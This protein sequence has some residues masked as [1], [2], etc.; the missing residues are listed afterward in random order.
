[1]SGGVDCLGRGRGCGSLGAS[2]L[3][4]RLSRLGRMWK[5]GLYVKACQVTKLSLPHSNR[6]S[7]VYTLLQKTDV[8][9]CFDHR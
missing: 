5:L 8:R 2:G 7:K 9:L 6:P 4:Q 3:G 1:M